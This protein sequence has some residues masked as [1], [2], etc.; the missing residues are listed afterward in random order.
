MLLLLSGDISLNPGRTPNSVSQSFWKPFENKGL[1]FLHL[2]I[3]SILPKLD[4]QKT[5]AGNT[6]AEII[7]ITESKLENSISDS[8]VEILGYCILRCDR[9]RNGGGVACYVRQDLCF[10]L[11]STAMGDIEGIVF[12]ILLPKTKPIFVGIIYRPP[13]CKNFLE[14]FN[15]HLDDINLENEIVLFG[16]F[17]INL[18][19]NG[20]CILKEN[21]AMQNRIPSTSL[22]SPY[23]LFCQRCSLE[24][25]IKHATRTTCSS[26]TLIY[27]ILTN[28]RE[29][30]S[31]SGVIDI[32]ISDHQLI[33]LTRKLHKFKS[34]THK[35]IKIRSLKNYSI[36]SLN[37]GLSMINFSD[38]EYFNDVDIAY[39]HFIQRITPV[40]NKIAPFKEIRI[41]NYS[42]DWFDGEILDKII[43][44]DKRLKKFKASRFNI[45]EQ[46]HKEA[47]INVQK[48]IKI[49]KR[50]FYQEKLR[51]NVGKPKELWKA[52]K[53][54]GLPP[55]INTDSQ[56]SLKD[57]E[58]IS[59]DEKTYN[60]SFK[61]FYTNLALNL[62]NK[63][64]HAP[65]KFA[66][67]SVL[68]Y[69][70]RFLNTENQ[71]FT[72][73]PTSEDEILKLLTDTNR[74][75]AAGIVNL[76]GRFL[77]DGA[78]VLALPISKLCNLSTKR[79]KFLLDCKIAKLKPLYKKGSK[80]NPK[81]Y[82][83]VS[84]LPLVSK[85]I[86]KVIHNETDIFLNKNK[87]LYNYQSGFRKSFSTNS[88]L[89]L[90][91]DKI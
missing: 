42:H 83:P 19:H 76:S 48:L 79:S 8:E 82:R 65:N 24:Q 88:R 40:I 56:V 41:K 9:S 71:K 35:Q 67:H 72:F 20:K 63:L 29:K 68:A 85:V 74:E 58:T 64:A 73:S 16:D 60:N 37:Q 27:H 10:N 5:I 17:N 45:D 39:S 21:Q 33:Y 75:K 47:K 34:N 7:G 4:E 70:K 14:C 61:N 46:L 80:A 23:K 43:L 30:I 2:N 81:N 13:A 52:L 49:K 78:V 87:I 6:K 62:I 53:S 12:D 44:R 91:T 54:L 36:E 31:Q 77:K 1:H 86:E 59:F 3:N 15:K 25:I 57:G 69:Y 32:G 26:S 89:T 90:L 51:E 55:K 50:D 38:Y 84:L 28:S 18:F 22:V 11:R 66:L